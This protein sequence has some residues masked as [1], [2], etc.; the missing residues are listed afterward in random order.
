MIVLLLCICLFLPLLPTAFAED[1]CKVTPCTVPVRIGENKAELRALTASYDYNTY[2]S[3]RSLAEVLAGSEKQYTIEYCY[4]QE[5]GSY[6]RITSGGS[7]TPV[8]DQTPESEEELFLAPGRYRIFLDGN[9]KKYYTMWYGKPEDL[10]MNLTDALLLF[11]LYAVYEADGTV[12]IDP[13][14]SFS[15]DIGKL[16]EEGYFDAVNSVLV[17]DSANGKQLFAKDE[18]RAFPVASTSKLMTYLLVAEALKDG[19]VHPD[20]RVK[21]SAA[22]QK[23]AQSEDG[24]IKLEEGD[25]IPLSELI[26]AMMVASS[27]ESALAIAEYVSG[28]EAAFVRE[29]NSKAKKLGMNTAVFYNC[30]GLPQYR[31]S[32]VPTKQQNRMSANDMAT[33]VCHILSYFPEITEITSQQFARMETM[34]YTTANSNPLVFNIEGVTGLKTGNTKMAGSC[35]VACNYD[36]KIVIVLGA[37]DNSLRGRMAEILFR[38]T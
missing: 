35:L 17:V 23:V 25:E 32:V 27:N 21:I 29:M 12:Q 14:Q 24:I 31:M 18:T 8:A 3:L 20:D 4:T 15:A 19:R 6:F 34:D 7:Y 2:I 30:N 26:T 22:V 33:L 38:C 13:K 11:D 16:E 10:F 36:G 1:Y 5:D 37:E 9:E 28:S